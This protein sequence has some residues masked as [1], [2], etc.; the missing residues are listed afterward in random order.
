MFGRDSR[1]EKIG[2]G[3]FSRTNIEEFAA[4]SSLRTVSQ[5]AFQNC[6]ALKRVILNEG[7][8][9]LGT[10]EYP[11]DGKRYYGVFQ[12]SAVESISLPST[13]KRIE[14][15][16][17]Q[18]CKNLRIIALPKGLEKIGTMCLSESGIEQI[19]LPDSVM[20][21]SEGTFGC[22]ERLKSIVFGEN[23]KL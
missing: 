20:E 19:V 23:S 7:L 22:C 8:E 18:N 21:I 9:V 16:A 1:L 13:L 3:T 14:Y 5:A 12:E 6:Q 4:P 11:E 17:F 15:S 2:V 10:D